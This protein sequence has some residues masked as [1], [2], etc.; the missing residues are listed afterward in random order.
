MKN[1]YIALSILFFCSP[2]LTSTP[3]HAPLQKSSGKR[4]APK[5]T[6][7]TLEDDIFALPTMYGFVP[8]PAEQ[9]PQPV[10]RKIT[11]DEDDN[12]KQNT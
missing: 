9:A 6:N 11:F 4:P 10:K 1:Q 5:R 2:L 12:S 7:N 3:P 8:P